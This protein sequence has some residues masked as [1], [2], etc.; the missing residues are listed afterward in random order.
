MEKVK[1]AVII[2]LK[3]IAGILGTA[4]FLG[5]FFGA[6]G[7]FYWPLGWIYI[8]YV[9]ICHSISAYLVWRKNPSLLL[10]RG[11]F[12]EGTKR[13]DKI[14][15]SIFGL[16]FYALVF[17]GALDSGRYHWLP[18]PIWG[19][20]IGA[21]L[22]IFNIYLI[23]WA[24]LVNPHFEKTVR[25][26]HDQEHR[27]I[28]SGPYQYVRHPGYTGTILGFIFATPLLFCSGVAFVPAI[29]CAIAL[30][31]RTNLEDRLLL[32]ELPGYKEYA[33][34]VRFRLFPGIW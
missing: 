30:I 6:A 9:T 18:L 16:S 11:S 26:Q 15:L 31:V 25:I 5:L 24:M 12:G 3:I 28:D 17:V 10:R 19:W 29:F 21:I 13:W 22:Y 23:T 1:A 2:L 34:K 7:S 8:V 4:I 32:D 33:E 14:L 27:V 20:F